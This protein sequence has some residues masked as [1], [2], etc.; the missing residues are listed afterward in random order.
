MFDPRA[1]AQPPGPL[2][3]FAALLMGAGP[4]YAQAIYSSYLSQ[5]EGFVVPTLGETLLTIMLLYTVF[6]GLLLIAHMI[7]CRDSLS[8]FNQRAGSTSVDARSG[9]MLAITLFV[10]IFAFGAVMQRLQRESMPAAVHEIGKALAADPLLFAVWIGPVAWLQAGLFEELVR[11]FMLIRLWKIWPRARLLMVLV[12][13]I[14]FGLAHY[15]QGWI[16]VVGTLLIGLVLGLHYMRYG[17]FLP[18][19]IAHALYDSGTLLLLTA[20]ARAGVI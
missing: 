13:A 4:V 18:L 19:V 6:G 12:S 9:I 2:I 5:R 1:A 14:P 10:V 7:L 15:Y 16:G 17:R 3:Q 20:A 11:T 8:S